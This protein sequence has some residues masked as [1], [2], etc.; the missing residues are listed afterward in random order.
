MQAVQAAASR[1]AARRNVQTRN[2]Q[3]AD[4]ASETGQPGS[5]SLMAEG[6]AVV[7]DCAPEATQTPAEAAPASEPAEPT[8]AEVR[9]ALA[10]LAAAESAG[11]DSDARDSAATPPPTCMALTLLAEAR[12]APADSPAD[13][14]P[15]RAP[16][17]TSAA[18]AA[19]ELFTEA[20]EAFPSVEWLLVTL[21]YDE[22]PPPALAAFDV[23]PPLP[24]SAFPHRL[25]LLHRCACFHSGLGALSRVV[26]TLGCCQV[27]CMLSGF[28]TQ[29]VSY[30]LATGMF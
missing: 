22:A 15:V 10:A 24:A 2:S 11:G 9:A 13:S 7:A 14:S 26:T 3:Q 6:D 1:K 20:F 21:P 30:I 12:D 28:G 17:A 29:P 25:Y 18:A 27:C 19:A 16:V 8:D 23:V 4:N 5:G